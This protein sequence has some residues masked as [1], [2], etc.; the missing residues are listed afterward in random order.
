MVHHTQHR[1]VHAL[2]Q[3][4]QVKE[5]LQGEGEGEVG[6]EGLEGHNMNVQRTHICTVLP[7]GSGTGAVLNRMRLNNRSTP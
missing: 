4:S 3:T 2:P 1:T 5:N 7:C 6:E